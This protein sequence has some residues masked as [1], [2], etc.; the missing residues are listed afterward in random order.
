MKHREEKGRKVMRIL[1]SG[2][3]PS[4]APRQ[5]LSP[6]PGE[7]GLWTQEFWHTCPVCG[8]GVGHHISY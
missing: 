4:Y 5:R 8:G 6:P 1:R 3:A 2:I 7:V